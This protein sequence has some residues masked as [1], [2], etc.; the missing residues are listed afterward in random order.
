MKRYLLITLLVAS[1]LGACA[2]TDPTPP[3]TPG[4]PIDPAFNNLLE[5]EILRDVAYM[6]PI[7]DEPHTD[8]LKLDFY[9][10]VGAGPWP[11]LLILHGSSAT[12]DGFQIYSR[13]LA[14]HGMIVVTPTWLSTVPDP[15]PFDAQSFRFEEETLLCAL[16]FAQAKAEEYNGSNSS[17]TVMGH[18]AGAMMGVPIAFAGEDLIDRWE[19]FAERRGGPAQQVEC[20][21]D[22][23]S[24][25]HVDRYI[26][27]SGSYDY[28]EQLQATNGTVGL[29]NIDIELWSLVSPYAFMGDNMDLRVRLIHG[30]QD[31]TVP[32]PIAFDFQE[33]LLNTGYDSVLR[34]PED[35]HNLEY[36]LSLGLMLDIMGE[37]DD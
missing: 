2:S 7:E 9:A 11:V 25:P 22:D 18:S 8:E 24:I 16:R 12:K 35:G 15:T 14:G 1:L 6:R 26:G 3:P 36:Y 20:V 10:P 23:G 28:F 29:R 30:I 27:M 5:V 32:V 17:F 31:P 34:L 19:A 33:A 13:T 21:E 37:A 4:I